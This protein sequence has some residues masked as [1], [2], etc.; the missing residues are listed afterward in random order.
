MPAGAPAP[1]CAVPTVIERRGEVI[2]PIVGWA[3]TPRTRARGVLGRSHL[4][5]EGAFI[6]CGAKQVHTFG[7]DRPIDVA[8]CDRDW[9]VLHV[10]RAMRPNRIGRV[11][12]R[13]HYVVEADSG[14]L[15]K[16]A[17]GDRLDLR[18]H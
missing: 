16:V 14:A 13:G 6:L 9:V 17:R 12:V 8:L 5:G 2:V 10:A 3:E 7:L 18:E 11:V 4:L 1:Y 15:R